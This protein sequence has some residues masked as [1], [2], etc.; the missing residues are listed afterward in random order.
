MPA[1]TRRTPCGQRVDAQCHPGQVE[2]GEGR[3][4]GHL[5]PAVGPQQVNGALG[6]R[7][8][9]GHGVD[10]G[11]GYR[12]DRRRH[13][14]LDDPGVDLV[15]RRGRLVEVIEGRHALEAGGR[16]MAGRPEIGASLGRRPRQLFGGV[17][18]QKIGAGGPE[19][20]HHDVGAAPRHAQPL[21]GVDEAE[22]E[23]EDAPPVPV[24][25]C[26]RLVTEYPCSRVP[27]APV[28]DRHPSHPHPRPPTL[29][30]TPRPAR[31][32][33]WPPH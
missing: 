10:D 7:R 13:Q 2:E 12:L 27:V 14:R 33:R 21:V 5:H 28:P 17:I 15:E 29:T 22:P 4:C 16:R 30:P 8:R 19:A 6:H 26:P 32:A 3:T 9:P 25:P 31:R 1:S 20:H 24:F 23:D 11:F 18:P